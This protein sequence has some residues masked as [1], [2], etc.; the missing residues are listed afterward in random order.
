MHD[1]LDLDLE[2]VNDL[3]DEDEEVFVPLRPND[4]SG[5]YYE[6]TQRSLQELRLQREEDSVLARQAMDRELEKLHRLF[7]RQDFLG[8]RGRHQQR[9]QRRRPAVSDTSSSS[10]TDALDLGTPLLRETLKPRSYTPGPRLDGHRWEGRLQGPRDLMDTD[11]DTS[12]SERDLSSKDKARLPAE[13]SRR[14]R[15]CKENKSEGHHSHHS[16]HRWTARAQH[17]GA[18]SG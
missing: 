11:Q 8:T 13:G 17:C 2:E 7:F 6:D 15:V 4:R 18:V 1:D 3:S 12:R 9:R 5:D 16:S 10:D 14:K